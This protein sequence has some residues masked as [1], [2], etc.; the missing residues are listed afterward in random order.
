MTTPRPRAAVELALLFGG[1]L[2]L[3]YALPHRLAGDGQIRFDSLRELLERGRWADMKYSMLGPLFSAPLYWL[4]K[5]IETPEWWCARFN[6]CVLALALLAIELLLRSHID[7]RLVRK[8]QLLLVFGSMFPSH[9]EDYY[10]EPFSAVTVGVG[11]LAVQFGRPYFGW[12]TAVLGVVNTPAMVIGLAMVG[13]TASLQNNRFRHCVPVV[14]AMLLIMAEAWIRRGSPLTSGYDD[15][16]G[17]ATRL[18]YSGRP[19]FSYPF[20]FGLISI[21]FSFGKGIL[22]FAPGLLLGVSGTETASDRLARVHRLWL[23]V[24]VGLVLVYSKWWSWYGGWYWGPRFFLFASLPA[25]LAVAARLHTQRHAS[26]LSNTATL[27]VLGLS[28]WVAASGAVF[29]NESLPET[30]TDN[31]YA[32]EALC[33][34]VPEFSPLFR[35]FVVRMPLST[36]QLVTLGYAALLFIHLSASLWAKVASDAWEIGSVWVRRIRSTHWRF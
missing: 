36:A 33:W 12:T 13:V 32:L 31:D 11:L 17:F 30:C 19:G 23:W 8:F 1:I 7:P 22:L 29:G 5:L 35:P 2:I 26:L 25:A 18:P 10:G 3:F 28:V 16:H 15:D 4:G 9:V 20:F 27:A 34:Y 14:A 21:L 6:V 24:V